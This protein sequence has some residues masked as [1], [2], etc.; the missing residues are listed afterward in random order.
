MENTQEVQRSPLHY[1]K[2][3]FRRKHIIMIPTVIGL[4][5]GTAVGFLLP[6]TYESS[7]VILVEEGRV[8]NPLIQG[9]A[10]S[11][12][13]AD[14]LRT[15]R[16]QILSWDRL[17]QLTKRLDLA[18]GIK[19]QWDFEKLIH[20]LRERII[21][22]LRGPNL[23]LISYQDNNPARTQLVVKT[24]TDIFIEENIAMQNRE[25]ESAIGFINDQLKVYKRKIKES[26]LAQRED[27]LKSLLTDS[28]EQHP[29]VKELRAEITRLKKE[30]ETGDFEV[31]APQD[32]TN[33]LVTRIQEE[34]GRIQAGGRDPA[35]VPSPLQENATQPAAVGASQDKLY[36]LVLLDQLSTVLAKDIRVNEQIYNMLLQRLETAKITRRLEA[37]QEGTRYT[38]LDPARLPLRPIKPSKI[39]TAILG[40]FV[41]AMVGVGIVF[42]VEFFDRS[43]VSV[44]EAKAFLEGPILG[45]ISRITTQEELE[46]IRRRKRFFGLPVFVNGCAAFFV[47][48]VSAVRG[49]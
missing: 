21:V 45:A 28:T 15:L 27:E 26:E 44:E 5:M 8:I 12:S 41:G 20:L 34:I 33:P 25:T 36:N 17:V 22:G 30:V 18:K 47:G 7:T 3:F 35:V 6:K 29:R 43:F 39:L 2:V 11:T 23:I 24:V 13:L 42:S 31:K 32:T 4:L 40:L 16:E 19:S 10:V 48:I 14:R 1:V 49:R 38:I 9:L 46:E 37:S